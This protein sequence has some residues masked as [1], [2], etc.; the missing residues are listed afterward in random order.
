MDAV[1]TVRVRDVREVDDALQAALLH[2]W[3]DVVNAGGAVGFVAPVTREDV[4]P[5]LSATLEPV[6]AGQ[7]AL[8]VLEVAGEVAGFAFLVSNDLPLRRHWVTVHRVQVH[9]SRQGAGLGRTL[10]LGVHD[11]ARA[12]GWEALL[13]TVR[14]ETGTE[15]F[16]AKLGYEQVG[17]IPRAIRVADGDDRD[18]IWM[19]RAL[20]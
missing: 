15:A 18:E 1:S 9:P 2:C 17:R 5:L 10:L 14:G 7:D 6:R 12:R 4:A 11:I 19:R 13:L 16:Y 3:T 20:L 8:C